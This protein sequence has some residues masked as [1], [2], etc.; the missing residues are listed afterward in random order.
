MIHSSPPT[1]GVAPGVAWCGLVAVIGSRVVDASTV[2]RRLAAADLAGPAADRAF[3]LAALERCEQLLGAH[4]LAAL[5]A[6]ASAGRQP[7]D[8]VRP[9][10]VVI[11]AADL[12]A[13]PARA[14]QERAGAHALARVLAAAYPDALL[15]PAGDA[16]EPDG[17][18]W[19]P[20]LAGRRPAGFA[21]HDAHKLGLPRVDR[22]P[23]RAAY[24]AVRVA[25]AH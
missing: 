19:P 14:S 20:V 8:G 11:R 4:E 6:L 13:P 5:A 1:L 22:R 7:P 24:A 21:A 15:V 18:D 12:P 16:G 23:E 9:W 17:G 10:R 3:D 2:A 25:E